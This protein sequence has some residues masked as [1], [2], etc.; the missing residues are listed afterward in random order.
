M[1]KTRRETNHPETLHMVENRN[2]TP[3][4]MQKYE[5]EN[6]QTLIKHIFFAI[7]TKKQYLNLQTTTPE[8]NHDHT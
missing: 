8:V 5:K 2:L 4:T 1:L 7:K 3:K 6:K